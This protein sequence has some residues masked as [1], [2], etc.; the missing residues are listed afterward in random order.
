MIAAKFNKQG[1][2]SFLNIISKFMPN[3]FIKLIS[4]LTRENRGKFSRAD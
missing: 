1:R 3:P 2:A 4:V